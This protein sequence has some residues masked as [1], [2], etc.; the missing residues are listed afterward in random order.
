RLDGLF[1]G[2]LD[3]VTMSE[4]DI[5][6][7][8]A[9]SFQAVVDRLHDVL[10]RQAAISDHVGHRPV[11]LARYDDVVAR[12]VEVCER[13]TDHDLGLAARV[14]IG[15]V[16]EVDAKFDGASEY[17][18]NRLLLLDGLAV[19]GPGSQADGAD[20][21]AAVAQS[22]VLHDASW[23]DGTAPARSVSP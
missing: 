5:D 11:H 22:S 20:L 8:H 9:Q 18:V 13:L 1:D 21:Q 2:R 10:A 4:V 19:R 17:V 7:V 15:V 3:V 23:R 16:E 6:V 14:D 12:N